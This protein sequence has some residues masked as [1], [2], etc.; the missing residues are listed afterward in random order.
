MSTG[1]VIWFVSAGIVGLVW[2]LRVFVIRRAIRTRELLS[3]ASYDANSRLLDPVP[4]V[5][6]IVA[7][8]DEENNIESCVTT[9]LDQDYP[10]FEVIAVDDRSVD[11]TPEILARLKAEA[12]DRLKV[13]T[14]KELREGWF[15]KC[16]AMR[17]GAALSTGDWLL[18]TD[19]DCRQTSRSTISVA[20]RHAIEHRTDFLSVTPVLETHAAWERILQPV[21]AAVLIIW[22]LPSRVNNPTKK[23]AYAN[24]AFMLLRRACYQGIGGH[25]SVRRVINED[26]HMARLA[27]ASGFMLRVAENEDLYKTRMYARPIEAWHGWTRIFYGA[28]GSFPR[29]TGAI[30]LLSFFSL[31]PWISL[32]VALVG[33]ATVAPTEA[34]PWNIAIAV[35]AGAIVMKQIVMWRMYGILRSS[36]LW[37]LTYILGCV[38][39]FVLLLNAM[40]GT[41]GAGQTTWRGM[42]YQ[43]KDEVNPDLPAVACEPAPAGVPKEPAAHV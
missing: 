12:P 11:R 33:R 36:G 15:G 26:I 16:N 23:A 35:W 17:E 9:L 28:L 14:V 1:F 5:S 25:D 6:V 21:C 3:S 42:Q 41:L 27:K 29:V 8:K 7:A 37:S 32:V 40:R 19:A 34:G 43:R 2:F 10:D 24:G 31:Q 30:A 22:F 38:A 39:T 13:V 18:F 4:R 20:I